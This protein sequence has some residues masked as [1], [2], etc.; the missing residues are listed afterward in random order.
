MLFLAPVP[1]LLMLAR[2]A[3][4][5]SKSSRIGRPSLLATMAALAALPHV[6]DFV[7]GHSLAALARLADV[8]SNRVVDERGGID[9]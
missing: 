6:D 7:D 8:V 1:L 5:V 2:W 4:G 9:A 3:R